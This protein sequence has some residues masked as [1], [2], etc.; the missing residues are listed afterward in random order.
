MSAGTRGR[1]FSRII[2]R[3]GRMCLEAV[4]EIVRDVLQG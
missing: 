1:L 2:E 4:R 3:M